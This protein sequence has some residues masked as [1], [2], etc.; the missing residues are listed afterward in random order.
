MR[1]T[2]VG[3]E[4]RQVF[5]NELGFTREY[6]Q[7]ELTQ[8]VKEQIELLLNDSEIFEK[9]LNDL[10]KEKF[11]MY[12]I[13]ELNKHSWRYG[14]TSDKTIENIARVVLE[15]KVKT[16]MEELFTEHVKFDIKVSHNTNKDTE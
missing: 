14:E 10:L 1:N 11:R 7:A 2:A 4:F 3:K 15:D 16:K 8:V 6:I 5:Y 9:N 12:L 13:G